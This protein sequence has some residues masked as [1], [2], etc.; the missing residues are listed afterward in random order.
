M[1]PFEAANSPRG[2]GWHNSDGVLPNLVY[3]P[4]SQ[5]S[6]EAV[7]GFHAAPEAAQL[8]VGSGVGTFVGRALGSVVG[9]GVGGG[10]GTGVGALLG[11]GE[12]CGVGESDGLL[13]GVCVGSKDSVGCCVGSGMV[14]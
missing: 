6:Q 14:G 8:G 11:D 2:Q 7:A 4:T 10:V 9:H 5:S 12:G 1:L 3:H 13:V